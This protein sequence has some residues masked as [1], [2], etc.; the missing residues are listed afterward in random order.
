[1]HGSS[2]T[3]AA[4]T[5]HDSSQIVALR[6]SL[7]DWLDSRGISQWDPG[8]V[9]QE[10]VDR[11]ISAG[12]WWILPAVTGLVAALR[13]LWSD[14]AIWKDDTVF[15]GYVH[16]LMV[17]RDCAGR[18]VGAELLRWAEHQ[19]SAA[20]ASELRLDCVETNTRLRTYYARLGFKEVGRR[21]F[22]NLYSAVLLSKHLH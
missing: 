6:R 10:D 19:A 2:S 14:K 9:G 3:I 16:G 17:H 15:A 12:E 7:E 1:M 21:D 13:L 22:D 18:G 20:G 8:Q 4:A 5:L 11:Q